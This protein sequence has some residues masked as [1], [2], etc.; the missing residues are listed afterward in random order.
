[1]KDNFPQL[2]IGNGYDIHRLVPDRDLIIGG[3]KLQHPKGIGLDGHSDADVLVHALMD[4]MLGAL[5]LGDI[6]KYFPPDSSEWEN[7]NSLILLSK[8][9]GLIRNEGWVVVNVDSVIIAERPKMKPYIS[10]MRQNISNSIGIDIDSIG[11]K[12]TTNELL[13]AEGREEGISSHA[14]VLLEKI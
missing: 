11:V 2:R 14:V 12:A 13:G 4:A 8:V 9:S 10:L 6:G 1:M 3:V 7:A 5:G